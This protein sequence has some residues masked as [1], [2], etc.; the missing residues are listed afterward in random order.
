MKKYISKLGE[1]VDEDMPFFLHVY[2]SCNKSPGGN[3]L[4]RIP[5]LMGA[6]FLEEI[7]ESHRNF[8][9]SQRIMVSGQTEGPAGSCPELTINFLTAFSLLP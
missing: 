1:H 4:G 3:S 9:N 7:Q 2:L 5:G 8:S 6:R